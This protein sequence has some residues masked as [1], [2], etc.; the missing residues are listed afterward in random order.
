M[1]KKCFSKIVVTAMSFVLLC[2]AATTAYA[3]NTATDS[4]SAVSSASSTDASAEVAKTSSS[5]PLSVSAS[6]RPNLPLIQITTEDGELPAYEVVTS[7]EG[8]AGESITNNEYVNGTMV[9]S[10]SGVLAGQYE[11]KFKIRG[12]TSAVENEKKP[13]KIKLSEKADLLNRGSSY[14]DKTW[15]LLSTGTNLK[16]Y[17][18]DLVSNKVGMEWTPSMTFVNVEIN[19]DWQ[20]LYILTEAVEDGSNRVNISSSGYLFENDAYW[21]NE[22][23]YF[24]TSGQAGYLAYTFK[25]PEI[26]SQKDS[27][28]LAVKSLMQK[29]ENYLNAGSSSLWSVIDA[30]SWSRWLLAR[31]ILGQGD[32]SGSNIYFYKNS[33]SSADLVKMGPLWD[34]DSAFMHEDDW[35]E[36]HEVTYLP[37][38][39]LVENETF[40]E[41]YIA[42][43]KEI[44]DTL[45][46]E[47]FAQL[48]QLQKTQGA[49]I[50]KSRQLDKKRWGGAYVPIETEIK[51]V[52]AYFTSHLSWMNQKIAAGDI[53]AT[54]EEDTDSSPSAASSGSN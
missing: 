3:S 23:Y 41:N 24:R 51:N 25:Y 12:N 33:A 30:S 8:Y 48:D 52:K 34:F 19:G 40:A 53:S 1:T 29:A 4:S 22:D 47:I 28:L 50:N 27:R 49:A 43:W 6:E 45:Q 10:G 9:L 36:Q 17:I 46:S 14:A 11:M 26:T 54:Y 44:S 13:Y 2:G 15:I 42:A 32:P 35:S 38:Y 16:T 37:Y 7:S 39:K 5:D 20:G 18:G 31:D 21:W